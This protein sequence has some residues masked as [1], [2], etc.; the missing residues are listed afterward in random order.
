MLLTIILIILF[1]LVGLPIL[2]YLI[3][4]FAHLFSSRGFR[5]ILGFVLFAFLGL[6]GVALI[7]LDKINLFWG[8]LTLPFFLYI[9]VWNKKLNHINE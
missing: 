9:Y 4:L 8:I 7:W 2:I 5:Q 6:V 3:L 1:I